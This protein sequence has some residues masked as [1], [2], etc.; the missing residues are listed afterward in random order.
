MLEDIKVVIRSCIAKK[1][2]QYNYQKKRVKNKNKD[3][4][5]STQKDIDYMKTLNLLRSQLEMKIMR[6]EDSS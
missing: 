6:M 1:D 3:L 5:N 4:Q 2:R